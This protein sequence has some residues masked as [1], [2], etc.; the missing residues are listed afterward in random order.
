MTARGRTNGHFGGIM[1]SPHL[2]QFAPTSKTV[3]AL[4]PSAESDRAATHVAFPGYDAATDD[5]GP[6]SDVGKGSN[7][8]PLVGTWHQG[9]ILQ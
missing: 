9:F 3:P 8:G 1:A 6:A 5:W 2:L 7:G 4:P